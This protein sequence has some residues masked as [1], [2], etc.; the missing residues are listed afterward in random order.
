[1]S[2]VERTGLVI[3]HCLFSS[4]KGK[5]CT[6]LSFCGL[7]ICRFCFVLFVVASLFSWSEELSSHRSS[8]K[9]WPRVTSFVMDWRSGLNPTQQ[10][11]LSFLYM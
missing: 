1:V 9:H 11:K 4:P 10:T 7:V 5:Y 8:E 6:R 2:V 3:D